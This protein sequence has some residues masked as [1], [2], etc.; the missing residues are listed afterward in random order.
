M[1]SQEY[2]NL[3]RLDK[4][5][6]MVWFCCFALYQPAGNDDDSGPTIG[7]QCEI[8]PPPFAQAIRAAARKDQM[9]S[10]HTNTHVI[11]PHNPHADGVDNMYNRLWCVY[12]MHYAFSEARC[13]NFIACSDQY[14]KYLM[15]KGEAHQYGAVRVK[16]KDAFCSDDED[17]RSFQSDG[18]KR[19]CTVDDRSIR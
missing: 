2:F 1:L 3:K 6:T 8:K 18:F 7:A 14:L 15:M 4:K 12:E 9:V 5:N 19:L 10:I 13:R 17:K 16:T 11:S